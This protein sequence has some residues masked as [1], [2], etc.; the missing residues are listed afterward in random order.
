MKSA[1]QLHPGA[2]PE[3]PG[4]F[5]PALA[6]QWIRCRGFT[7]IEICLAVFISLMLITL[8]VPS[9][10]RLLNES[11]GRETF[12]RFDALVRHAQSLAVTERRPYLLEWD[13]SGVLMRPE[14]PA[15]REEEAGL[16]RVDYGEKEVCDI[17]FP[18]ALVK[19]P[20]REWIFWPSGTC[21]PATVT[22]KGKGE[23]WSADYDPLTL[24]ATVMNNEKK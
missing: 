23:S 21:E 7:L 20:S 3:N 5:R 6:I 9:I 1:P 8:A 24:Q 17:D 18:A 14:K 11:K 12:D 10:E 13:D 15:T 22:Y 19:K 4:P 16:D 2:F